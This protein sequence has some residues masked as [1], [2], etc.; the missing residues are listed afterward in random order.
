MRTI[1]AAAR[2]GEQGQ[3]RRR[4]DLRQPG[5]GSLHGLQRGK[6]DRTPRS[7]PAGRSAGATHE[8]DHGLRSHEHDEQD[9][10]GA[11]A[12]AERPELHRQGVPGQGE[13]HGRFQRASR[14]GA[15]LRGSDSPAGP[16]PAPHPQAMADHRR[17]RQAG[18]EDRG[19]DHRGQQ[20][21]QGGG[22][23]DLRPSRLDEVTGCGP[24]SR[25]TAPSTKYSG[26]LEAG[27]KR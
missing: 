12:D 8:G 11:L 24:A 23:K 1:L 2:T 22:R 15:R 16:E 17:S 7:R 21:G 6:G 13:G 4:E 10:E 14:R 26:P 27:G 5:G 9:Q 20:D 25:E 19:D 3:L 18:R